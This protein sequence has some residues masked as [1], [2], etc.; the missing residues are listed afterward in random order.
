MH[1]SHK[2]RIWKNKILIFTYIHTRIEGLR[3][4]E[5]LESLAQGV[6]G[7]V[8]N[9]ICILSCEDHTYQEF[10]SL[11]QLMW[12]SFKKLLGF[13]YQEFEGL[14]VWLGVAGVDRLVFEV[15]ELGDLGVG[16]ISRSGLT[17]MRGRSCLRGEDKGRD[18]D[19]VL[20][21][22]QGMRIKKCSIDVKY[23]TSCARLKASTVTRRRKKVIDVVEENF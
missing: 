1:W 10:E 21:K 17:T 22:N 11:V 9:Y 8:R 12:D 14:V 6:W 16:D 3:L 23:E 18:Q 5:K 2:T 13:M 7:R 15:L 4:N 20:R 19:D